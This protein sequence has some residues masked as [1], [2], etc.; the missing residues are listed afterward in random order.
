MLTLVV[1]AVGVACPSVLL[2]RRASDR[3]VAVSEAQRAVAARQIEDRVSR[4]VGEAAEVLDHVEEALRRGVVAVA[5]GPRPL[6]SILFLELLDHL[7]VVEVSFTCG[8]GAPW[9]VVAYRPRRQAL[10]EISTRVTVDIVEH[11]IAGRPPAVTPWMRHHFR[12]RVTDRT[13]GDGTGQGR[14]T[15]DVEVPDPRRQSTYEK[16][17]KGAHRG[18]AQ[19]NDLHYAAADEGLPPAERRIVMGVQKA[20]LDR[21]DQE[22]GVV[23]VEIDAGSIDELA[24]V[25]FEDVADPG[26]HR[27]FVCD[28]KGRLITRIHPGDSIV[29]DG[30]DLRVKPHLPDPVISRA[31]ASPLLATLDEQHGFASGRFED[32]RPPSTI[33]AGVLERLGLARR[34]QFLTLRAVPGRLGWVVGVVVPE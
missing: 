7:D 29:A 25:R 2:V 23:H 34:Q 31:L 26:V 9:Q 14:V 30:E 16:S 6:E 1:V 28:R 3:L 24:R 17:T 33:T 4:R 32:P 11:G 21:K 22:V 5:D 12:A 18:R 13:S 15:D 8:D 19:W 20:L 27:A 10:Y